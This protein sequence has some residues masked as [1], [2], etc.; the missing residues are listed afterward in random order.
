VGGWGDD[1]RAAV[2]RKEEQSG[3]GRSVKIL[4]CVWEQKAKDILPS[5][6]SRV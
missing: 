6:A 5:C 2:Q 3:H 4:L 1:R